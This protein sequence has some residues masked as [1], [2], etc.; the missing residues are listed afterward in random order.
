MA[1]ALVLAG[2]FGSFVLLNLVGSQPRSLA[3]GAAEATI[4]APAGIESV[5]ASPTMPGV[6]LGPAPSA[7]EPPRAAGPDSGIAQ[8]PAAGSSADAARLVLGFEHG[9][10]AGRLRVWMDGELLLEEPLDSRV[11]R[12]L[13]VLKGRK[14][15]VARTLEVPPGTHQIKVQV[16]WDRN[17]RTRLV[18]A[19]FEPGSKRQL[20]ARLGGLAGKSLSLEWE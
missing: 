17:V 7:P 14:G 2:F 10:K 19:S 1:T 16:S 8:S 18:R 4:A 13:L 6:V 5:T 20:S 3:P 12:K 11:T 15:A 9:L